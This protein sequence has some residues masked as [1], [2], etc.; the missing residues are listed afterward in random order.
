MD[1]PPSAV[2]VD[3]R[4]ELERLRQENAELRMDRELLVKSSGLLRQRE[5]LEPERAFEVIDAEKA[6]HSITRMSDLLGVSRS[7][8]YTRAAR[9]ASEPGEKVSREAVARLMRENKIR[10]ISPRPWRPVTTISGQAVHAIPDLAER[11]FDRGNL[12]VVWTSD[13]T[14][15]ATDE[16]WLYLCAVRD[17]CRRR[18]LGCAFADT[19]HT[20][21]VE[22]AL[23][24]PSST[25]GITSPPTPR[26]SPP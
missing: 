18:V 26:R 23:R 17:G 14:Y 24:R 16:G 5:H 13:I 1:D 10:G 15:L 25:N 20:D 19:L 9:Q 8:Y 21:L 6:T 22:T 12:N 2:D 7:G 3:E 11:D 4:A